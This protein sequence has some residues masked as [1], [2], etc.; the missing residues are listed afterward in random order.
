MA[1]PYNKSFWA[2]CTPFDLC[3]KT[4]CCPCVVFG[5]NHYRAEHGTDQG[6]NTM[7]GWCAAW[8]GLAMVGHFGWI[9]QFLNRTDMQEKYSMS[10]PFPGMHISV[11][12]YYRPRRKC[13][14]G[15]LWQLVLYLL[16]A[17]A[18]GKGVGIY[19]SVSRSC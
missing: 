15:V 3:I 9:L 12:D 13:M 16:R 14:L 4:T 2:C 8:C 17:D 1:R 6:Y 19:S 7:N 10:S 5:K 18:D 11:T